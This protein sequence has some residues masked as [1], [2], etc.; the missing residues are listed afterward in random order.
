MAYSASSSSARLRQAK[1]SRA[2]RPGGRFRRL[3]FTFLAEPKM[4]LSRYGH[5]SGGLLVIRAFAR[6][7]VTGGGEEL[8]HAPIAD[9]LNLGRI[10]I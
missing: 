6:Q 8:L 3:D 10:A 1:P 5:F 2:Q 9:N 4:A 7:Q